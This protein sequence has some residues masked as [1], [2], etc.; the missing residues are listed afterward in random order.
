MFKQL[1]KINYINVALFLFFS[2]SV[3]IPEVIESS[4]R[5]GVADT[6]YNLAND[7]VGIKMLNPSFVGDFAP[8]MPATNAAESEFFM[9]V[10]EI[11]G[12]AEPAIEIPEIISWTGTTPSIA[13]ISGDLYILQ[14]HQSELSQPFPV[15]VETSIRVS[16][17]DLV[18][19]LLNPLVSTAGIKH[20]KI[21][22][23]ATTIDVSATPALTLTTSTLSNKEDLLQIDYSVSC[24]SVVGNLTQGS[25][26]NIAVMAEG[27]RADQ[28]NDYIA[29][30]ADAFSDA[31]SLHEVESTT[32]PPAGDPNGSHTHYSNDYFARYW[33]RINVVRYD[34]VSP[35]AGID[36]NKKE[37][38]VQ[39]IL[40]Y[41]NDT[42]K[43]D[44]PRIK[45]VIK[46][47]SCLAFDN[48]DAV[49]VFVNSDE[50]RSHTWSHGNAIQFRNME[51]THYVIMETPTG[52]N[53][54]SSAFH[55]YVRTN[56]IAHELGHA[57]ARLQAEYIEADKCSLLDYI[58]REFMGD[59][60]NIEYRYN[61]EYK[62]FYFITT[63]GH[64]HRFPVDS[65]EGALYCQ[66]DF[67]R[68]T[69][70]STMRGEVGPHGIQFGPVNTYWMVWTFKYRTG[71]KSWYQTY[72]I[73]DFVNEWPVSDF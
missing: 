65:F 59:L 28:M 29:Y 56:A 38:T 40:D 53:P 17:S 50:V 19:N 47:S 39:S 33:N 61:W 20:G 6:S 4:F 62:W 45:A 66:N 54:I 44:M 10:Q 63:Y 25:K 16:G 70:F 12:S 21:S 7:Q 9:T 60:R 1:V 34:T 11:H 68:S 55:L 3:S 64:A 67:F 69:E 57:L 27:F 46:Q 43:A 23:I 13:D 35:Q 36:T 24:S 26:M 30:V 71:D 37:D 52:F 49:I 8:Y 22:S 18:T 42:G 15:S 31:G 48:V 32:A 14:S 72:N 73:D 5:C 58:G 41:N 2:C 51:P